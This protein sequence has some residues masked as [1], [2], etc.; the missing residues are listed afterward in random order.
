VGEAI[1][2]RTGWLAELKVGHEVVVEPANSYSP[3]TIAKVERITPTGILQVD[4]Q[5]FNADGH[6]PRM[7]NWPGP[8]IRRVTEQDRIDIARAGMLARLKATK[9]AALPDDVL[10]AV[11]AL[12]PHV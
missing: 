11:L 10:A 7:G 9:W 2:K 3:I 12:V 5:R 1:D 6:G 4:G 8:S